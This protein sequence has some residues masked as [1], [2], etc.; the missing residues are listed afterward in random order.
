MASGL[1]LPLS[2]LEMK[3]TGA[4][5]SNF[6]SNAPSWLAKKLK[7]NSKTE[8]EDEDVSIYSNS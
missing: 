1:E 8:N 2:K 5:G 7:H 3:A 4:F 6:E